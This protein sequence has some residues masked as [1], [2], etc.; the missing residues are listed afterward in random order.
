M[1]EQIAIDFEEEEKN[2][3]SITFLPKHEM[4]GEFEEK[5]KMTNSLNNSDSSDFNYLSANSIF[6]SGA[7]Y[8]PVNGEYVRHSSYCEKP[9]WKHKSLGLEMQ[10]WYNNHDGKYPGVGQWRIGKGCSYIY[11]C[12]IWKHESNN[13]PVNS[14]E[15]TLQEAKHGSKNSSGVAPYPVVSIARSVAEVD[16]VK[17]K[18]VEAADI[19]G[20]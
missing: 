6:V 8:S 18:A 4:I 10:L 5:G 16:C 12:N 20:T 19:Q 9:L 3:Y 14:G 7:G 13:G 15:W 2:R 1:L 17:L 11:V